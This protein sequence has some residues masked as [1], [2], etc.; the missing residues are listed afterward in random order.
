MGDPQRDPVQY[1]RAIRGEAQTTLAGIE[2]ANEWD[3]TKRADWAGEAR[4]H[5]R[6]LHAAAKAEPALAGVPVLGPSLAHGDNRTALGNVGAWTDMANIHAY[7][8]GRAPGTFDDQ[9]E[10]Y[11]RDVSGG[12][13]IVV[14]ETGYHN[15]ML[16]YGGH[17][18]TSEAATAVYLPRLFL[19]NF[20][21]GIRRT[22][23]YE[24][25]N[26]YRDTYKVHPDSNFGLLDADWKPKP[27]YATVRNLMRLVDP[28]AADAPAGSLDYE[29]QSASGVQQVLLRRADGSFA[30]VLWQTAPV[31][32]AYG[33]RALT[34]APRTVGLRLA[35]PADV[36]VG[37]VS[38]GTQL[39]AAA[40]GAV[41][42]SVTVPGDDTV[43]VVIRPTGAPAPPTQP[44][45]VTDTDGT[46]PTTP[47]TPTTTTTTT[48]TSPSVT[49]QWRRAMEN[50]RRQLGLRNGQAPAKTSTSSRAGKASTKQAKAKTKKKQQAKRKAKAKR[51]AAARR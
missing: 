25:V 23:A 51:K 40:T 50:L 35:A 6:R 15:A 27:A 18:A 46:T 34:V 33:R 11:G 30:L 28:Q 39:T 10:A 5:Q 9:L 36:S 1:V 14:T 38:V 19:D 43:V 2:G 4:D 45:V 37:R 7:P 26:T 20:R 22:Y 41:Q 12:Q 29:L 44:P 49:E 32:D 8:G 24:L 47:T 3:A 16:Q 42:T 17:P 21:R 31:W 13:P 48:T